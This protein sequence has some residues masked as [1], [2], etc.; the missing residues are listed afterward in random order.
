MNKL[1]VALFLLALPLL[2]LGCKG[3][4]SQ[5]QQQLNQE[6]TL[7]IWG[8]LD[9]QDDFADSIVA[10]KVEHPNA[11][12]VYKKFRLEEYE[13]ALLDAFAED[14]G[15]D[16][17]AVHN[18]WVKRYVGKLLALPPKLTIPVLVTTGTIKQETKAEL[19]SVASITPSQV[20]QNYP[21]VVSSDAV[22]KDQIYGLP[23]SI[24]SLAL[25]Y[26]KSMLDR[27]GFPIPPRTWDDVTQMV[28]KLTIQ[29]GRGGLVQSGIALGTSNNVERSTDILSALMMQNGAQV[30]D[31]A[32]SNAVFDRP[33]KT[34][35][36]YFP[37]LSALQFY[38]D[39]ANPA[40]EVYSW[41]D[42]LPNS[43]DAFAQER[44][45]MV[46]GYSYHNQIIR[47][48][49]PRLNFSVTTL[50]QITGTSRPLTLTN[51]W[52]YGVSKKSK[53]PNESWSFVQNMTS[54]KGS[55]SYLKKTGRPAAVRGVI[56]Q[57]LQDPDRQTFAS[58]TLIA[59][60]W[61]P[62]Y[63]VSIAEDALKDLINGY[64][65]NPASLRDLSRVISGK[66]GQ[67]LRQP[68]F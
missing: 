30:F 12:V 60:R 25:Y 35:N 29:D 43:I 37:G 67:S 36:Q 32:G 48:Q 14:R 23:L 19:R 64:M 40:K 3:G 47:A 59:Q 6:K 34:D 57:D 24:D 20:R 49:N 28:K 42:K 55:A 50:P 31:D 1:R 2:G 15:P 65:L 45:A 16:I 66:L 56:S 61:F 8:V 13:K 62:G 7:T 39:F 33:S 5:A 68:T 26:N 52:V 21:D 4:N 11:N 18:T 44:V 38:T 22:I 54:A 41:H 17:F 58:Q 10:W 27:A 46:L 51:Y 53:S 9:S 63:D